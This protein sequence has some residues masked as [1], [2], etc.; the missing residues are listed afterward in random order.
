MRGGG[1]ALDQE[2]LD[3]EV[4]K[5]IGGTKAASSAADDQNRY[6]NFTHL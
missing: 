1:M 5:E 3:A 2:R 4:G 6:F